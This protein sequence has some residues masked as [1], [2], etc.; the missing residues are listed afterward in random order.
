MVKFHHHLTPLPQAA[1]TLNHLPDFEFELVSS[2][3]K[4]ITL[5]NCSKKLS[6][7]SKLREALT[8]RRAKCR[9]TLNSDQG[10]VY[11]LR[12]LCKPRVS[13]TRPA[14]CWAG[15]RCAFSHS[16]HQNEASLS[17]VFSP[18]SATKEEK[19][20]VLPICELPASSDCKSNQEKLSP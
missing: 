19:Q 18:P 3:T 12:C 10:K 2:M 17:F 16:E 4:Q 14:T 8:K 5:K 13:S 15:S 9:P 6:S 7:R 1:P 11:S 20:S